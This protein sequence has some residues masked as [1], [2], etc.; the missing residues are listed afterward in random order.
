MT[1]TY[2]QLV[3]RA[4]FNKLYTHLTLN[5]SGWDLQYWW[6]NESFEGIAAHLINCPKPDGAPNWDFLL[7]RSDVY[8]RK[9]REQ[10]DARTSNQKSHFQHALYMVND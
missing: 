4:I 1:Y 3:R 6:L 7:E 10:D 2:E 8:Q 5:G 9:R